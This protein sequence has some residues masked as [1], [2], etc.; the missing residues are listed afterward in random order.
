MRCRDVG[1][2]VKAGE[3]VTEVTSVGTPT[4]ELF[5]AYRRADA[6]GHAGRIGGHLIGHLGPGQ[7]FKDVESLSPGQDFVDVIRQML[8]RA[9]CMVVV[10]GPR[11]AN[12]NRIHDQDDLHREE[13][14]T[15]LERGIDIIPV[16]VHG[17][18]MPLKNDLPVDIQ[19]I[20]RRQAIEIT[21]TRWEYDVGR[22]AETVAQALA[23]SPR[24]RRFLEQVPPWGHKGPQWVTD[25]PGPRDK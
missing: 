15:A 5:I 10:I 25:D 7:V 6:P 20:V 3:V 12:D 14:R 4:W 22:L 19:P 16:L 8:H 1:E 2:V 21:D 23:R 17:A 24:R 13:I 9:F 11:W 18:T